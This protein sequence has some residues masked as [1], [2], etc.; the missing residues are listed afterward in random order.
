MEELQ[1]KKE[2]TARAL[3]A[4]SAKNQE[5]EARLHHLSA[6]ASSSEQELRSEAAEVNPARIVGLR[7]ARVIRAC[8]S[9]CKIPL[10][11]IKSREYGA[12]SIAAMCMVL[13]L[14]KEDQQNSVWDVLPSRQQNST[15]LHGACLSA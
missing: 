11:Q 7:N 9:H 15:L 12:G 1:K 6:S 2:E 4:V 3:K 14:I 5:L 13:P 8:G 10:W